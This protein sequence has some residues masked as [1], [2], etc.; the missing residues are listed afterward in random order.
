MAN[1]IYGMFNVASTALLTQQ[2]A[3]DV[4]ANNIANVNTEGYSRQRVNMEQNEPVRYEGG[5]LGT[6]VQAHRYIQ[7]VYDQFV[8]AQLVDSE[9]LSGRWEAELETLEKAELMFDETSGY[10]LNDALSQF[11]NSWQELSNDPSGYTERVTLIADTQNLTAVFNNLYEG[12]AEVQSDSDKSIAEAVNQINTLTSEIAE[13]NLKIVEVEAS[14]HSANEFNDARDMKLRELSGLI[15]INSFEDAD[16][17]LTITSVDGN[18]LVDRTSSWELTTH[19]NTEG[20]Q[21]VFWVSS[22]GT[23]ENITDGIGTGKLKGWIEARDE[24]IVDYKDRLNELATTIIGEVNALHTSGNTLEGT[25]TVDFFAGSDA[26]DI[27]INTNIANNA[28]LIAAALGTEAVPGGNGNALAIADLQNTLTMST[29]TATFDDFYNALAGDVGS[30]VAQA[31]TNNDHQSAVSLQLSTYREEIS[32]V[33][34]DEEM[35]ALVQF[36][37]AY[38]AA[39]KLVST[40]DEL[41]DSLIAMV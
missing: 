4:T 6:G 10:G 33:S 29:N 24:T 22:S 14:G 9:S 1:I 23:E 38:N 7:R 21:D 20:F 32:G 16:G 5:T 8:N 28:N 27:A 26:S 25:T 2:K 17:Y 15:D 36:Q 3:L 39:A 34:L 13:L 35:I 11:W 31:Q 40:V 19:E 18:T 37:S 30:G 41:L 12:L